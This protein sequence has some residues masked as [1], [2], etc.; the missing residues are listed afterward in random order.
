MKR[1]TF[2][3]L[4]ILFFLQ[5]PSA[6]AYTGSYGIL[7]GAFGGPSSVQVTRFDLNTEDGVHAIDMGLRYIHSMIVETTEPVDTH[8]LIKEYPEGSDQAFDIIVP[9]KINDAL[10]QATIYMWAPDAP[11]LVIRHEHHGAPVT[12]ETATKVIPIQSDDAGNMLWVFSVTSFS[13]F[14]P[15]ETISDSLAHGRSYSWTFG[16]SLTVLAML[17]IMV[18]LAFRPR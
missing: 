9:Q 1:L 18:P 5:I 16:I 8:I 13:S 4:P 2:F 7:P 14:T 15:F 11:S 17:T 10:Q 6:K 3:F 12:Y